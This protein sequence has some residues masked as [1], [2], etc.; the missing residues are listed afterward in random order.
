M[1][2]LAAEGLSKSFDT[3][4]LFKD[5]SFHVD[6]G[7]KIALVGANGSGKTTLL[8]ILAGSESP[9]SGK[10]SFGKD[11]K[12]GFL[13]QQPVFDQPGDVLQWVLSA[14]E[15]PFPTL[16]AYEEALWKSQQGDEKATETLGELMERMDALQAWDIDS[17]IRQ[18]LGK[19][20]IHDLHQDIHSL[21]GG[22]R[23]RVALAKTLIQKPDLLILD[24]PTNHLDIQS[25]EWLESYLDFQ[26]ITLLLVTHDRY[27]LQKVCNDIIELD[28]GKLY[29]YKGTYGQYLEKK[30]AR[31]ELEVKE[32]EKARNLMRKELEWVRRQPKARGT[33]AKYRLDAFEDLKEK[34]GKKLGKAEVEIQLSTQRQGGKILEVTHLCKRFGEKNIIDDFSYTFRK[35]EKI[36]L[37]GANGAGKSTLINMLTG[38]LAADSGSIS[39]GITT[40]FGYYTQEDFP[41]KEDM[42]VIDAI[43]EVAEVIP[44]KDGSVITASQLL[45]RFLFSPEQQYSIIAKLSGGEKRRLQ[46]LRVLMLNPNFLILDEPTNDLDIPTLN[47]LEDYLEQFEGSLLVVSHDRYFMDRLVEHLFVLEGE[48]KWSDFPGNYTEYRL[49]KDEEEKTQAQKEKEKAKN[50]TANHQPIEEKKPEQAS[51]KRKASYKEQKEYEQLEKE[52]EKLENQKSQLVEQLNT[53]TDYEQLS[54]ISKELETIEEAL[55]AKSMRWL[56]LSELIEG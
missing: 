25:I 23:K 22:Q 39:P 50:I 15:E 3:R 7:Q 12:V 1:N 10:V 2:Y 6:Q 21:S 33:K 9:D 20:D 44:L 49:T 40:V 29:R 28:G 37:V 54:L 8:R 48:G 32:V 56:E 5:I 27:F 34:A 51:A 19:L 52:I 35:R 18:I 43:Q 55:E 26:N 30:A 53:G 47:V 16:R 46:L 31:E 4:I 38:H 14:P 42:R 41:F 11:I 13:P 24:E 17:Q 45:Q 36:G